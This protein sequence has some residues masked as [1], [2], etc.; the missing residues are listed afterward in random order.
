MAFIILI[1]LIVIKVSISHF[2]DILGVGDLFCSLS[3]QRAYIKITS[4]RPKP[5][6]A[7]SNSSFEMAW[8][9]MPVL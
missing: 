4:A 8:G 7:R 3:E 9:E 1:F 5:T 6:V 2:Q